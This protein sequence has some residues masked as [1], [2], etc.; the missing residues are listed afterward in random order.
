MLDRQQARC[1]IELAVMVKHSQPPL[2]SLTM[3]LTPPMS[4]EIHDHGNNDPIEF[5]LGES[6]KTVAKFAWQNIR[7]NVELRN[8]Q[9][10]KRQHLVEERELLL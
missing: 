10:R 9:D 7:A 5:D 6:Y 4:H 3:R 8:Q 2:R 1:D